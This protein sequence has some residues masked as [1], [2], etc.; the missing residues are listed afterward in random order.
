MLCC[1]SWKDSGQLDEL[2]WVGVCAQKL[3][4]WFSLWCFIFMYI[5]SQQG[6]EK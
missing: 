1:P 5:S 4:T 6:L 3:F 2:D